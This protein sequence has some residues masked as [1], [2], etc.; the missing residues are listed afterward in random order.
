MIPK[1]PDL[2]PHPSPRRRSL[3]LRWALLC[4]LLTL[5]VSP[6]ASAQGG[7]RDWEAE[8]EIPSA[9]VQAITE[10]RLVISPQQTVE[11]GALV[12]RDGR[13]E[14]IGAEVE[15]PPEAQVYAHPGKTVYPGLIEIHWPQP[16]PSATSSGGRGRGAESRG[17]GRGEGSEAEGPAATYRNEQVRSHRDYSTLNLD[18]DR[19][20]ALRS[21]GFTTA[22][23]TPE[24]GV[25]GGSS[26]LINLGD[27]EAGTNLLRT[28]V[29]QH[30]APAEPEGFGGGYPNSLMGAVA[31]LRQVVTEARWYQDAKTASSEGAAGPR[32]PFDRSLE[33]LGPAVR[34]EAPLVI[35][36]PD[37]RA[38]LRNARLM[39]ELE[40]DGW[41]V[42]S[43]KEYR[44]AETIAA[45]G[46]P[47]VLPLDF[48]A[49]PE[50][51][52]APHE[53]KAKAGSKGDSKPKTKGEKQDGSKGEKQDTPLVD[54]PAL[55][56]DTLR[57]WD[58]A[59]SNPARMVAAGASVAL[60]T[61]GLDKAQDLY[62]SAARARQAGLSEADLLAALTLGPAQL[63]GL[64]SS[65]GS[66]EAGKMANFLVV[67]GELFPSEGKPKIEQVWIDGRRYAAEAPSAGGPP[68]SGRRGGP[69]G[70]SR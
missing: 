56:L 22:L 60:T 10:V 33:A 18:E 61:A 26:A 64:E 50:L 55:T 35:H 29:A 4:L 65:A 24:D 17:R 23:I 36:G 45:T 68:G 16:W 48:P 34:G 20:K 37:E 5:I 15:I 32:P 70:E 47:L 31:L 59:P 62:S 54:D 25:L 39:N 12:L 3:P 7:A 58:Q 66:L 63:L 69:S 9:E 1:L 46:W 11:R 19:V 67:D 38:T 30:V 57:H 51:P 28:A 41:L 2:S 21:A 52:K 8:P 6:Q 14:A 13:I 42:G 40:L 43:G 53:E 27:G 44:R 49:A